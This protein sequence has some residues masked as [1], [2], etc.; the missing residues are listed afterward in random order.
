M[1]TRWARKLGAEQRDILS[2]LSEGILGTTKTTLR[3]RYAELR[4]TLNKTNPNFH[5]L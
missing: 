4:R 2:D 5:L 3:G 1:G